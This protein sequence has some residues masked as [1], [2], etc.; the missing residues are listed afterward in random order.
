MEVSVACIVVT[1]QNANAIQG[2]GTTAIGLR[3]GLPSIIV[4]FFGDQMFWGDSI[5]RAGA[6]PVPVP[7]KKLNV[8][9]LSR[10]IETALDPQVKEMAEKIGVDIRNEKGELKGVDSFHAHLPILNMRYDLPLVH[11]GTLAAHSITQV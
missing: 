5:H 1:S 7:P 3:N 2:A 4:P 6:G 10:A 11:Y 8:D 9:S